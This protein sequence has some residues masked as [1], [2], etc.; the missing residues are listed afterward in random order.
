MGRCYLVEIVATAR[1]VPAVMRDGRVAWRQG[2]A[3]GAV[4]TASELSFLVV[5][6]ATVIA[7]PA[8]SSAAAGPFIKGNFELKVAHA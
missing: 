4:T 8:G 3:V 2:A 1:T 7:Y 6:S 5:L